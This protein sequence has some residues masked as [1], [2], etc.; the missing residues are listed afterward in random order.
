MI[1]RIFQHSRL[2]ALAAIT[3]CFLLASNANAVLLPGPQAGGATG[4]WSWSFIVGFGVPMNTPTTVDGM[5]ITASGGSLPSLTVTGSSRPNYNPNIPDGYTGTI[6]DSILTYYFSVDGPIRGVVVPV[7]IS[8]QYDSYMGGVGGWVQSSVNTTRNWW[9]YDT[10]SSICYDGVGLGCGGGN[11]FDIQ[12]SAV[13]NLLE[14]TSL[15]NFNQVIDPAI[16]C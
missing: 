13:S 9:N 11:L 2:T 16:N 15:G 12:T 5:T 14:D 3:S 6:V 4:E 8:G 10:F 7:I 1:T